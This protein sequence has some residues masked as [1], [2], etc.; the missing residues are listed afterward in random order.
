MNNIPQDMYCI[1]ESHL[2]LID[3]LH[4][5]QCNRYFL[6]IL[7]NNL[8]NK[9]KIKKK[10]INKYI[11]PVLHKIMNGIQTLVFAP[12]I[13]Y[14]PSF[15]GST[16]Y[17][18]NIKIEDL[19]YPIMIGQDDSKRSFIVF[20]LKTG[21]TINNY[22]YHVNT[23]FQRYSD[24]KHRWMSATN[25]IFFLTNETGLSTSVNKIHHILLEKNIKLLLNKENY[26]LNYT[27][28]NELKKIYHI[29]LYYHDEPPK[30]PPNTPFAAI[31]SG[32]AI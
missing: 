12:F 16:G 7:K 18:D 5:C 15:C 13:K 25:T 10:W 6:S 27:I 17:L 9:I 3:I 23:L 19:P 4:L 2:E 26:V 32:A 28:S 30:P 21:Y 29:E 31:G 14:R 24:C 8:Q 11:V 20:K 22:K 1:I